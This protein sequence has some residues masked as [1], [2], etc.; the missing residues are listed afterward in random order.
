MIP[1]L[2]TERFQSRIP[3]YLRKRNEMIFFQTQIEVAHKD[4]FRSGIYCEQAKIESNKIPFEISQAALNIISRFHK[5]SELTDTEFSELIVMNI[6]DYKKYRS[7]L[8]NLCLI[9][10]S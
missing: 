8:K 10:T 1:K 6:E 4:G 5:L 7:Y 3:L 2:L 9:V